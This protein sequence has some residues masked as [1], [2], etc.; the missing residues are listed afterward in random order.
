VGGSSHRWEGAATGRRE[1]PQV[2][3]SS[4]V[5]RVKALALSVETPHN[6]GYP[7]KT[8]GKTRLAQ[9]IGCFV[10]VFMRVAC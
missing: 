1:Q 10:Q 5:L 9:K 3:G 4:N 8:C 2:G 6:A 7:R